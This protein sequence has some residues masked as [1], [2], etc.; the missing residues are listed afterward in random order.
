[1]IVYNEREAEEF[2][3]LHYMECKSLLEN[4]HTIFG[5]VLCD[6]VR[7]V[8]LYYSIDPVGGSRGKGN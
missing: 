1:M 3:F 7:S 4:V 8:F 2:F 5:W 6:G